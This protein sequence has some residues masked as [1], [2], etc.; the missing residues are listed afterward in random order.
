MTQTVPTA[1]DSSH[2]PGNSKL[3][4]FRQEAKSWLANHSAPRLAGLDPDDV[5][6]ARLAWQRELYE[7]GWLGLS[8][9]TEYGGRGLT[10]MHDIVFSE[11]L[12]AVGAP[13]PIGTVGLDVVAP[14]ILAHGTETQKLQHLPRMLSGEDI[15]CQGFSEPDSGS[16]LASLSSRAE[17]HDEQFVIN[18]H[19]VWSTW[20]HKANMCALLVRT[21]RSAPLHRGISYLLVDLTAPGV[22]VRQIAQLSGESEFGELVFDNVHADRDALLGDLHGGWAYTL[23]SL[24]AERSRYAVR[25]TRELRIYLTEFVAEVNAV[26]AGWQ[27][28]EIAEIGRLQAQLYALQCQC[29]RAAVRQRERPGRA[30]P[31]DSFDKIALTGAE[32]HLLRFI[33]DCLGRYGNIAARA[34]RGA[35][36]RR[37][38]PSYLYSRAASIYGGTAQIQRNI[39]AERVLNLPVERPAHA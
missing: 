38:V 37:W 33:R 8:W 27:P 20:S 11:E 7:A 17:L 9:P 34:P 19:K 24:S 32:Q 13:G 21:D 26:G 31:Q 12:A 1:I 14:A 39:V 16:D 2:A 22:Q 28:G 29:E 25:R 36:G 5:F 15:W 18:G 10:P 35:A 6:A 3:A 4:I 23:Q 30:D